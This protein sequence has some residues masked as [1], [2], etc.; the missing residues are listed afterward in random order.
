ML[1]FI[2]NS[3][4][5]ISGM[6]TDLSEENIGFSFSIPP[7]QEE[8]IRKKGA[9]NFQFVDAY[10]DGSLQRTDVI[11]SRVQIKRMEVKDGVCSA[12]G[13]VH[14]EDFWSYVLKRKISGYF[15]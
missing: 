11:T 7:E 9:I 15:K 4:V 2:D 8:M 1:I 12:G 13:V 5:E 14:D 3:D 6:V 10:K